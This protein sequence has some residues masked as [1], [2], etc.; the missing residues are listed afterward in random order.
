MRKVIILIMLVVTALSFGQKHTVD[1][2]ELAG[3]KGIFVN[4]DQIF[5]VNIIAGDTKDVVISSGIEGETY[6]SVLI[7]TKVENDLVVITVGRTP[8]FE[9]FDDKLA[10]HKVMS[11]EIDI[12]MP[13][14]LDLW[15]DSALA[16]VHASGNYK[17]VNINL[18]SGDCYLLDF[19]GNGVINTNRGDIMVETTSSSIQA[20][21]RHGKL[22]IDEIEAP[23]HRLELSSIDGNITVSQSK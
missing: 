3:L 11:V 12:T 1:Q 7:N 17:Y 10:A 23:V 4:S 14:N 18:S 5:R 8:D 15:V 20:H 22:L 16:S 2:L 9:A 19:T 21:S 6:E 13:R